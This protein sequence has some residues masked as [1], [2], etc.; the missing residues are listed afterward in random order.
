M[1]AL[2]QLT[3]VTTW[4]GRLAKALA[5]ASSEAE[6]VD[7]AS[8]AVNDLATGYGSRER[9]ASTTLRLQLLGGGMLCALGLV[10]GELPSA[11]VALAIC[12]VGGATLFGLTRPL[13]ELERRQREAVDSLVVLLFPSN[14]PDGPVQRGSARRRGHRT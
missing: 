9:W 3:T 8:E 1:Q 13:S 5:E 6:R 12:L 10:R 11:F 2:S 7:A 14:E 4:E